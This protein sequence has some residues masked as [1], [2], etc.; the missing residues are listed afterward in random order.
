MLSSSND[1]LPYELLWKVSDYKYLAK[2]CNNSSSWQT[3]LSHFNQAC[4]RGT[5]KKD[6]YFCLPRITSIDEGCT[7]PAV[8]GTTTDKHFAN[9]CER[10]FE[11]SLYLNWNVALNATNK[12]SIWSSHVHESFILLLLSIVRVFEAWGSRCRQIHSPRAAVPRGRKCR[13]SKNSS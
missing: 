2:D 9:I 5:S 6:H 8:R 1:I 7:H 4:S 13:A 10:I 3:R 12:H 11:R